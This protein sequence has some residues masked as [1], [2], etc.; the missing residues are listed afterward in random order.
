LKIKIIVINKYRKKE[1][2]EA[3]DHLT[4]QNQYQKKVFDIDFDIKI[5]SL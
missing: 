1:D 5:K 2:R 3:F 4:N